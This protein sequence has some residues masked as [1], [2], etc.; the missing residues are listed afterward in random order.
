M[1]YT[2]TLHTRSVEAYKACHLISQGVAS[3][4]NMLCLQRSKK[5][6]KDKL[7]YIPNKFT[8]HLYILQLAYY[9]VE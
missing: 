3:T 2:S 5:L 1:T 7:K 8:K 4:L 9:W 6:H